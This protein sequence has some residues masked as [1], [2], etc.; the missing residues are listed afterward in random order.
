MKKFKTIIPTLFILFVSLSAQS[1]VIVSLIFGDALNSPNTQFGLDIGANGS[2]VTNYDIAGFTGG[3]E[4]GMFFNWKYAD[5]LALYSGVMVNS[6]RGFS[7]DETLVDPE[8]DPE[9]ESGYEYRYMKTRLVYVGAHS[10]IRYY[11]SPSFSLAG[12]VNVSLRT[13]QDNEVHYKKDEADLGVKYSV[14]NEFL[15]IDMGPM[16]T[17]I[18][19]FKKG[20]GMSINA[21][22][23]YGLLDI[24]TEVPGY[25]NSYFF[26]LTA[27]ILIGAAKPDEM[28]DYMTPE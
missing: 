25:Q 19:Q 28:V 20:K 22:A 16:F 18:Y 14:K 4:A 11:L 2:S 10:S 15:P 12:G 1:Q 6:N 26:E 27:G 8:Y 5:K 21:K 13:K 7:G 3:L 23:Y 24:A 17:F 9:I